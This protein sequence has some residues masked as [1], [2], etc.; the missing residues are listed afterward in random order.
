MIKFKKSNFSGG[1]KVKFEIELSGIGWLNFNIEVNGQE[2]NFPASYVTEPL[3]DLLNSLVYILPG[4]VR[5]SLLQE[6]TS[7]TWDS[8]G[9]EV[10]WEL[11]LLSDSILKIQVSK[12]E[13]P[14]P[15]DTVCNLYEFLDV[16]TNAAGKLLK[17][18]GI[19]GFITSWDGLPFPITNFMKLR[20]Y[21][22]HRKPLPTE[23]IKEN[24]L[25]CRSNFEQELLMLKEFLD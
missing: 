15:I 21:A 9:D 11:E 19:M 18:H 20:Y 14:G 22:L 7:F 6:K 25:V 4:C 5:K 3:H 24:S 13:E 23:I 16:V 8:E 10:F 17:R 12:I 2:L 1:G